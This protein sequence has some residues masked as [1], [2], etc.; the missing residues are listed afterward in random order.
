LL[1][2]GDSFGATLTKALLY[3]HAKVRRKAEFAGRCLRLTHQGQLSRVWIFRA[4][5]NLRRSQCQIG[6]HDLSARRAPEI[7]AGCQK[8][9]PAG[10]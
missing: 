8:C 6:L 2:Q 5:W 10:L 3:E 9:F 1:Y 4:G 7:Y